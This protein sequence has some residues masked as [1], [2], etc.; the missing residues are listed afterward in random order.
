MAGQIGEITPDWTLIAQRIRNEATDN[1]DDTVAV[2]RFEGHGGTFVRGHG[3][4]TGVDTVEVDEVTYRATKAAV[5]ATGSRPFIPPIAGLDD[6]PYWTNRD[7][8]EAVELPASLTVIGGG[9]IGLELAQAYARFGVDIA[10]VEAM[11]HLLP[12]EE[13]E[14]GAMIAQVLAGEH[15]DV[16]VGALATAVSYDSDKFSVSL[17]DG[18]VVTSERLLV[19][20]GR[21]VDLA[22]IGVDAIDVETDLP[23]L[24]TDDNVRVVPGVWA[25]GDVTNRGKFTH[26]G[27][28]QAN[29][30]VADILGQP[31]EPANYSA[32]PRVTFTDPEVGSVGMNER[33]ARA[34]GLA[35]AVAT[36]PVPHTAR[37]WLHKAG[38]EGLVKL[39]ID[40]DSDVL[41][42]ATAV[43]PDGGEVLGLLSLAVHARVPV[44]TLRTMIYA[45][46][47]F[48]R[49]IEDALNEL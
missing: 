34:A 45:Y 14:V 41:V 28:Y 19:A 1:W 46:P 24:P 49:G 7:A 43:G 6:V 10:V 2:E 25:V 47:T 37:G 44:Q 11:D 36:K 22:G 27:I 9:A 40:T 12:H 5:V 35:L 17:A 42:G 23:G 3:R 30:V 13:P 8:V 32:V 38:N 21:R 18:T 15:I 33:E 20:A 48:H 26:V 31:H 4:M 29:I 16:H 39:V